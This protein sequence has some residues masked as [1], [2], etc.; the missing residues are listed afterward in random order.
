LPQKKKKKAKAA[1][2]DIL[3]QLDLAHN[4]LHLLIILALELVEHRIAVLAPR[5]R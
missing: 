5:R 3:Q 4:P 2:T 1:T